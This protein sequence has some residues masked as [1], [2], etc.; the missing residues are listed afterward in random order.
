MYLYGYRRMKGSHNDRKTSDVTQGKTCEPFVNAM[1]DF[2]K[3]VGGF[4]I[5]N[6][7]FMRK[8]NTLGFSGASA[9]G[10]HQRITWLDGPSFC[11]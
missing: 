1:T 7:C 2:K 3:R 6:Q 5:G 9:S 10:D 4:R 11:R 8:Y